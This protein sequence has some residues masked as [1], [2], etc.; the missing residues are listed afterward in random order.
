MQLLKT[1]T[2][3]QWLCTQAHIHLIIGSIKESKGQK[4]LKNQKV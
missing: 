2:N 1:M 3:L 4:Y